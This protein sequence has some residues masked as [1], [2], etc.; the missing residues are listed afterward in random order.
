M[1]TLREKA[2]FGLYERREPRPVQRSD[3]THM[4]RLELEHDVGIGI[5][6]GC[7]PAGLINGLLFDLV[8]GKAWHN[9]P[10]IAFSGAR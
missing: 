7:V 10:A 4:G 3:K 1:P 5:G 2:P 6:T 8:V 9:S